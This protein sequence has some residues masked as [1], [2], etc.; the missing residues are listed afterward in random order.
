MAGCHRKSLIDMETAI[1]EEYKN[2]EKRKKWAELFG[3]DRLLTPEEF[4]C[5]VSKEIKN[6]RN[7]F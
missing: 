7:I 1:K 6:K 5:I 4:I 3:E 2:P